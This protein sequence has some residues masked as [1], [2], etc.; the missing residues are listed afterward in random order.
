[1]MMTLQNHVRQQPGGAM[2]M[3]TLQNAMRPQPGQSMF[4][5]DPVKLEP[6]E[7]QF[8]HPL[9][10][11]EG[12]QSTASGGYDATEGELLLRTLLP[13][14]CT[15]MLVYDTLSVYIGNG[16]LYSKNKVVSK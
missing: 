6:S 2:M 13:T 3:M 15:R 14:I 4:L 12:F 1:M 11:R 10:P 7:Q 16:N 5:R 9:S 8:A